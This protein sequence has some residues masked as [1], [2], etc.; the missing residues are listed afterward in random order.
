MS[1]PTIRFAPAIFAPCMH[2]EADPAEAEHH[3][4]VARLDLRGVDHRAD[5]GGDPA[6]DVAAGLERCVVTDLGHRDFRQDGEIGEGRA[7]HVMEDLLS[8]VTE[9][10]GSVGHQPLALRLADRA[11]QV[12]LARQAHFALAAFRRVERDHVIARHHADVTPAPTSRTI[13]APS[14]PS[15]LGNNPSLSSPSSV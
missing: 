5:A 3:D 9:P 12:G 13:P 8:L 11:A 2:V 10:A 14:W 4:I 1:T 6:A 7:A 15:T